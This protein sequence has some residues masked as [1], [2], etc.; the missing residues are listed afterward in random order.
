MATGLRAFGA[1]AR[2]RGDGIARAVARVLW[3]VMDIHLSSA[4]K[5]ILA[6]HP[7]PLRTGFVPPII[8]PTSVMADSDPRPAGA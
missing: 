4:S 8:T 5:I 1:G 3:I 6:I 7:S 2:I